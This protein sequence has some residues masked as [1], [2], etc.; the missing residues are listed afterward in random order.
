MAWT[1]GCATAVYRVIAPTRG[2]CVPTDFLGAVKP[3]MWLSDR[4]AAQLGHAEEHQFCL[5]L[6]WSAPCVKRR[7]PR[8][9]PAP[10]GWI[11]GDPNGP[12]PIGVIATMIAASPSL[13]ACR[14][15]RALDYNDFL[16][17]PR[18]CRTER[19]RRS[20]AAIGA[21]TTMCDCDRHLTQKTDY[22]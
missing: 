15:T 22:L 4:P 18:Q 20:R 5:A 10:T 9:F 11:A 19:G 6:Y 7:A 12:I 14:N 3:R 16:P 8:G 17:H 2:K 1:F 21:N 13:E